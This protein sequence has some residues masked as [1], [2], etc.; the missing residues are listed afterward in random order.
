MCYSPTMRKRARNLNLMVVIMFDGVNVAPHSRSRGTLQRETGG[1]NS[2]TEVRNLAIGNIIH[3]SCARGRLDEGGC[4]VH[5]G[6]RTMDEH[7]FEG[8]TPTTSPLTSSGAAAA[9]LFQVESLPVLTGLNQSQRSTTRMRNR[10]TTRITGSLAM[11]E[12]DSLAFSSTRARYPGSSNSGSAVTLLA[13]LASLSLTISELDTSLN[14]PITNVQQR[15]AH[16]FEVWKIC[17][18]GSIQFCRAWSA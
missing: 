16:R 14:K 2:D 15:W 5:G 17:L 1:T 4:N 11:F 3:E 10:R 18:I 8:S 12:T 7:W 9:L 6:A 13:R